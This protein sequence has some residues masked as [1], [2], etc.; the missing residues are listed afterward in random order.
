MLYILIIYYVIV[1][2][3]FM[4]FCNIFL[5]YSFCKFLNAF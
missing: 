2:L 5:Q 4:Q 3:F 1:H